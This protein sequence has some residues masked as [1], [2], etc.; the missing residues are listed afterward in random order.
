MPLE[1]PLTS[2]RIFVDHSTTEYF[3]NNGEAV[4]TTPS[5]PEAEEFHYTATDG[6]AVKIY[7]LS[8]SVRDDF[9]V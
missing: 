8:P 5:Y 3:V 7:R 9:V 2:L 4:F 6:A 1:N